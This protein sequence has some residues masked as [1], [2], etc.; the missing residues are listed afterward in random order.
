MACPNPVALR[1][2]GEVGISSKTVEL[3]HQLAEADPFGVATQPTKLA[4][5]LLFRTR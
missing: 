5:N 2:W 3:S 4:W 1:Q